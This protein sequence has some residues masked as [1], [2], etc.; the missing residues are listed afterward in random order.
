MENGHYYTCVKSKLYGICGG[1]PET[2]KSIFRGWPLGN[3]TD[4]VIRASIGFL[5]KK[6]FLWTFFKFD[7][8]IYDLL[9]IFY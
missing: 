2:K 5:R 8:Y 6:R 9:G 7:F 1:E 4:T 3:I